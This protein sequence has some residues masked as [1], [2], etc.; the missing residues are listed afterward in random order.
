MSQESRP[1]LKG[2][3]VWIR[4]QCIL[5]HHKPSQVRATLQATNPKANCRV[6]LILRD[7]LQPLRSKT[8]QAEKNGCLF[9]WVQPSHKRQGIVALLRACASLLPFT[10]TP[11]WKKISPKFFGCWVYQ[12]R[13]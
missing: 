12:T 13:I 8:N 4:C 2:K 9:V 10:Y 3:F 1:N 5:G 6:F 7:L 11:F